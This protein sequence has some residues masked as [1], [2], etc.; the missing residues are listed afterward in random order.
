MA[1]FGRAT[2]ISAAISAGTAGTGAILT[3][4]ANSHVRGQ[5]KHTTPAGSFTVVAGGI[6]LVTNGTAG[7]A[8][9]VYNIDLG[10]GQV[11]NV[12]TNTAGMTFQFSGVQYT[13][14]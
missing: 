5:L 12:T 14:A 7:P 9:Y 11:I 2:Y 13:N 10:P 3:V 4:A 6:N 1:S 8:P